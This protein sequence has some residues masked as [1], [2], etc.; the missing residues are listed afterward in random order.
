MTYQW[1]GRYRRHP[2]TIPLLAAVA[3]AVSFLSPV[4]PEALASTTTTTAVPGPNCSAALSGVALGRTGW[5]AST[6]APSNSADPPAY[7]LDGN[8]STRF[9]TNEPQAPG[10]YFE[11]N[12]GSPQAFDELKMAVPNSPTDYARGYDVEVSS[13]GST[14]ATVASCTGTGTPETV[15]FPT[16][17]AQ[18]VRVVLTESTADHWWSI[19]EF[20][21]FSQSA[22]PATTTTTVPPTTT[23]TAVPGSNCSAALSGVALGRT[24]WAASTNA[25]SNSADPPA[26]ALDGNYSTRFS[27]NEP[28]APG[29]YFEVNMGSPQAFD[30]LK[31]AVPNSPTDYARG[32]DVEVSSNGS[33]WATVAS[34]TGTGTPE[35]VSFPTQ[36]AQYVRVVLT[37]STAD[38]WWSIDEFKLFSQSAPP[39]TTTTTPPPR[40]V[41]RA[42]TGVTRVFNRSVALR[43][44]CA[45]TACRGFINLWHDGI[46]LGRGG[47][48]LGAG[49]TGTFLVRLDG[50]AMSLIHGAPRH[51]L[52]ANQVVLVNGGRRVRRG[53]LLVGSRP[54]P[55]TSALTGGPTRVFNGSV[56]LRLRCADTACRG[57]INLWHDGILLGHVSF[58]L[59][60]G[61]TGTFLVRLDGRAMGLIHGARGHVLYANQVV[62]VNGGPRVRR[63]IRLVG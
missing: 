23:T 40:P 34:C 7:A 63:G 55:V 38:H 44:R 45:D 60:A 17:T 8:Y 54:R 26:Y 27:T 36:T 5:A 53:T 35:T 24:G 33:T 50:R 41:V 51:V 39:S 32:Y 19:D 46:L 52:Y 2:V 31:M 25:P 12:M 16:Q 43:L 47:Y 57:F 37:E 30:E 28:Q 15:S 9:S 6:N 13:N 22:P 4:I 29:L 56:A 21:L 61:A 48:A 58:V 11:V 49:A 62:L 18:Y 59:A 14:W 20:K 42:Q 1:L 10:L 3:T